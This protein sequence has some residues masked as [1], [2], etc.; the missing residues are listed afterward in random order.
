M[1]RKFLD[2]TL[3]IASNN[4]NK[5]EEIKDF[6]SKFSNL[7][8]KFLTPADFNLDSPEETED[9]FTGNAELKARYYGEKTGLTALADDTGV[10]VDVLGGLPGVYTANWANDNG[11]FRTAI[12]RVEQAVKEINPGLSLPTAKAVC[13][14]SLY[15][16][17]DG[18]IETFIGESNGWLDFSLKHNKGIGFLPIFVLKDTMK[19]LSSLKSKQAYLYGHRGKALAKLKK[20]C[21]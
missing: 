14:M 3:L 13:A 1:H 12:N 20:A 18:H 10:C 21:F 9:T 8:I 6:F 16:P 19:T 17:T 11:D 2:D 5:V 15:W 4:P 7:N